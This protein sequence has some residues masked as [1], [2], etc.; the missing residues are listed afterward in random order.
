M[1]LV[2]AS[3][4]PLFPSDFRAILAPACHKELGIVQPEG[5]WRMARASH[6]QDVGAGPKIRTQ[7]PD[8]SGPTG[9]HNL[10]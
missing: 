5:F 6:L 10:F 4:G 7:L 2:P 8:N 3:T 9:Y 1:L